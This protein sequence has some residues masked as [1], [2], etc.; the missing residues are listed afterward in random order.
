MINTGIVSYWQQVTLRCK[1][2]SK[3]T[4]FSSVSI[5][6]FK[7]VN[8]CWVLVSEIVAQPEITCS[9][10][11]IET[12]EQGVKYV[13]NM[14]KTYFTLCSSISIVKFQQVNA[15]WRIRMKLCPE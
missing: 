13:W 2:C 9:K 6:N 5:V 15:D 1:I 10:L 4:T 11:T 3:L 7:Q 8:V 12:L 14:F